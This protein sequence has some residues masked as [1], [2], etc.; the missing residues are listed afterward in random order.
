MKSI[1]TDAP[2]KWNSIHALAKKDYISG[3]S[4]VTFAMQNTENL[5]LSKIIQMLK[6]LKINL[7]IQKA[8]FFYSTKKLTLKH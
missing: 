6:T 2:E 4:V 1:L 3:N 5:I 8:N 7:D